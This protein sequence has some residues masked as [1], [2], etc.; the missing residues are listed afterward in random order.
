MHSGEQELREGIRSMK[1]SLH[2]GIG[3]FR[4][5]TDVSLFIDEASRYVTIN[6]YFLRSSPKK[7]PRT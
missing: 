3:S 5:M 4:P 7:D 1:E 6:H 2:D